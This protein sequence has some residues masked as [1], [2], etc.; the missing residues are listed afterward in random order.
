MRT[1]SDFEPSTIRA[2]VWEFFWRL[3]SATVI[4]FGVVLVMALS[5]GGCTQS[6]AQGSEAMQ[7]TAHT[8]VTSEELAMVQAQLLEAARLAQAASDSVITLEQCRDRFWRAIEQPPSD[9][10]HWDQSEHLDYLV[11]LVQVRDR[12]EDRALFRLSGQMEL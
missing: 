5:M 9:I 12:C 3:G 10:A 8:L 11:Q 2:L 1:E 4:I 7:A 6:E